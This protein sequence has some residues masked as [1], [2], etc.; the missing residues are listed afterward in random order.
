MPQ[1]LSRKMHGL[2]CCCHTQIPRWPDCNPHNCR[3]IQCHLQRALQKRWSC[4]ITWVPYLWVPLPT[5]SYWIKHIM[6]NKWLAMTISNVQ[7][8]VFS[9]LERSSHVPGQAEAWL[10]CHTHWYF[11]SSSWC[12]VYFSFNVTTPIAAEQIVPK[13]TKTQVLCSLS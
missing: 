2:L 3:S 6:A 12:T 7:I 1:V 11:P 8:T 4:R 13:V 5:L 9:A 10:F